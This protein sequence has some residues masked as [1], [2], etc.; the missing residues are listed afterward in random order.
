MQSS[1]DFWL[2]SLPE[3]IKNLVLQSLSLYERE[4][5]QIETQHDYSF[6]VFPAAKAYEGF[7]KRYFFEVGLINKHTYEGKRFRIGRALN[8]DIHPRG[9]DEYWLYDDL[10]RKCGTD[11]AIELWDTWLTC[12]NGVFHYFPLHDNTLSLDQAKKFIE[13]ILGAI[14]LA[15]SCRRIA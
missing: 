4:K 5:N 2:E 12:R 10:Q 7:L 13:K 3:K 8:P 6:I 9:R 1:Q 11:A 15:Q 14:R